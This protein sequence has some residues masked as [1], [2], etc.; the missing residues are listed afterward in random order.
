MKVVNAKD[1]VLKETLGKGSF[2]ETIKVS[3]DDY[4]YC[5]KIITGCYNEDIW[6]NI[7]NLT[8][9]DFIKNFITPYSMVE[10]NNISIGYITKYYENLV[11]V[12]KIF[13]KDKIIILLKDLCKKIEILHK[14][15]KLIH[16]DIYL[17]IKQMNH[18]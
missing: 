2:G 14:E 10:R 15:Y 5:L 11:S 8:D 12:D 4:F 6:N 1:L 13:N 18:I 7:K 17:M 9:I 3:I 16:G